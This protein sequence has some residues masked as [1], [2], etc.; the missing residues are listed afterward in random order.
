MLALWRETNSR[1]SPAPIR[2]A[3]AWRVPDGALLPIRQLE[4][5]GGEHSRP[6]G[7]VLGLRVLRFVV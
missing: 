7:E 4:Q 1:R 6:G 2:H 5:R 3:D